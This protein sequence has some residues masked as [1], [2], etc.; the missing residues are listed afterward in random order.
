M[1]VRVADLSIGLR[2]KVI[3]IPG[4]NTVRQQG[5]RWAAWAPASPLYRDAPESS[6][7]LGPYLGTFAT[8]AE[9]TEAIRPFV[10]QVVATGTPIV[11]DLPPSL[12]ASCGTQASTSHVVYESRPHAT[13]VD[14][15]YETFQ[16]FGQVLAEAI[17]VAAGRDA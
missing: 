6:S 16:A 17:E 8:E 1:G 2:V 5:L 15:L 3:E 11:R 12:R 7:T 4:P 10:G 9:A 14:A 13:D